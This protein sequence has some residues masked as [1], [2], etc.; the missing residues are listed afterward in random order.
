[1]QLILR[2]PGGGIFLQQQCRCVSNRCNLPHRK[3]GFIQE[4]SYPFDTF[5]WQGTKHLLPKSVSSKSLFKIT[6]H[7]DTFFPQH[8]PWQRS[9]SKI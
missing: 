8:D 9:S 3:W 6:I 5:T 1:M 4:P 7:Q 2:I